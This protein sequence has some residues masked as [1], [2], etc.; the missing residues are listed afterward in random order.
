MDKKTTEPSGPGESR[1]AQ[2][3][4][5]SKVF[6]FPKAPHSYGKYVAKASPNKKWS[7]VFEPGIEYAMMRFQHEFRLVDPHKKV[8]EAFCGL[9]SP[10]QRAWWS[11]DSKIVGVPVDDPNGGLLLY[12]V[13]RRRYSLIPF[14]PYQETA[15][16]TST[17]VRIGVD[18]RE[19][20]AVFGTEFRPPR[21]LTFRFTTLRWFAVPE[22]G[23]LK[24]IEAYRSA[25]K[26]K[27]LPPPSK[28]MRAYAKAHG[29]QLLNIK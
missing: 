20:E 26:P 28:E 4:G 6:G 27:W 29:I 11:P 13:K 23:A 5:W 1:T 25:P 2:L 22:T 18:R 12:D 7:V 24:L 3:T 14:N 8:I 10:V 9:A 21:D 17:S 15:T 19:F 16:M